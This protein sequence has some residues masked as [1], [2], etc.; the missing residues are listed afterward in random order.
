MDRER[1]RSPDSAEPITSERIEQLKETCRKCREQK[2]G[3]KRHK[4]RL[5]GVCCGLLRFLIQLCIQIVQRSSSAT[6]PRLDIY[7]KR[8]PQEASAT[9][10][11]PIA[12]GH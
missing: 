11:T 1:S 10:R 4:R 3:G 12:R 9:S 8:Q 2:R 7:K 6:D 5:K